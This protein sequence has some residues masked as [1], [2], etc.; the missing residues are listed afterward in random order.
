M[1]TTTTQAEGI[2]HTLSAPSKMP[3]FSYNTPAYKCIK[4]SMLRKIKDSVCS[5]CYACKGRYLFK[6]VVEAMDKRFASLTDP[7]WT[8]AISFL[9]NKKEKS[10]FFRWH[11]SGDLQGTWHLGNIVKV[12]KNLPN[13]KFWLPTREYAM[14]SDY[15]SEG[16]SIPEN[17]CIRLSAL[18]IDGSIPSAIANR[19]GVV[20]SGVST[21]VGYTCPAPEQG[22]SCGDCRACWDNSTANINY[23]KH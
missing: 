10:G 11:D 23:K 13:I 21:G 2:T 16:N 17:L 20:T 1:F 3:G 5:F 22:N 12:A 6:N 18:L 4:G 8:E 7:L 14:V 19:L 15:I 9:I